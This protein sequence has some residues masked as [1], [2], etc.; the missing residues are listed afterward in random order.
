MNKLLGFLFVL[1]AYNSVVAQNF[2]S[3][4]TDDFKHSLDINSE[5]YLQ[6]NFIKTNIVYRLF[7]G[8]SID[9]NIV[10]RLTNKLPKSSTFFF[11]SS[12]N[13]KFKYQLSDNKQIGLNLS[14][15]LIGYGYL[16]NDLIRLIAEG[17]KIF[18]GNVA[19][20]NQS[21]MKAVRF[22]TIG[23][24]YKMKLDNQHLFKVG[25]NYLNGEFAVNSTLRH[26]SL[27][28]SPFGDELLLYANASFSITDSANTG[29]F[30]NNGSG[31]SIDLAYS[32]PLNI[33]KSDGQVAFFLNDLGQI[34]F[35]QNSINYNVDQSYAY[36]GIYIE[37]LTSYQ[38]S[39]FEE[40]N[41]DTVVTNILKQNN[42][43]EFLF[44]LPTTFGIHTTQSW[45]KNSETNIGF[46]YSQIAKGIPFAFLFHQQFINDHIYGS[47]SLSYGN[48][49]GLDFGLGLGFESNNIKLQISTAQLDGLI[50]SSYLSGAGI[51]LQF[52]YKIQ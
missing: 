15:R 4:I 25:A 35:N 23:A 21:Y 8:K 17:N 9:Q 39:V 40:Q 3:P 19:E 11:Q 14:D 42:L 44:K 12:Q 36:S 46:Y 16:S 37:N 29:M 7:N 32:I 6:S 22:Q 47:S 1:L 49:G 26:S 18:T 51:N 45:F 48:M 30:S 20:F 2:S 34:K 41:P 33:G 38:Q 5:N 43:G 52:K 31:F 50:L 24:T 13:I 27:Y 28:T 10:Y